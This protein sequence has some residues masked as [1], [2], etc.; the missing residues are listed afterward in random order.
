MERFVHIPIASAEQL[1][2][3]R[4]SGPGYRFVS[5]RLRDGR[6]Y[7]PAVASEGHIIQVRGH[8]NISFT[9]ADVESVAVTDKGWNF[10]KM[11]LGDVQRFAA[12][13]KAG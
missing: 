8:K 12:Y 5:I 9:S 10:R 3:E 4:E 2:K 1:E 6:C 7:E 11:R 13:G